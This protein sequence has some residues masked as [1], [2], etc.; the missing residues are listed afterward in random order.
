MKPT[1]VDAYR[2]MHDGALALARVE[3][4]GICVDVARL[5]ETIRDVGE[6]I[7]GLESEQK[8]DEVWSAWRRRFGA[9]ANM[10]SRDQLTKVVYDELGHKPEGTTR[11]GKRAKADVESLSKID[12]PFVRRFLEVEKLKKL[13]STYLM[14]VLREVVNGLLHPSFNLH[15]VRTYR[16]SSDSPNFQNIPI[17][18]EEVGAMIRRCFVPRPGHVLVEIDYKALEFRVCA[19]HWRDEAM[20]RYASDPAL[21]IHRDMAKELYLLDG[22]CS[23]DEMKRARFHAKNSFVFATLY[24]SYWRNTSRSLW[25]N[26]VRLT[27]GGEPMQSW[28][29]EQGI[30][31]LGDQNSR[32]GSRPGTYGYHVE[33]VERRFGERFPAWRDRKERWLELYR[34]RGWFKT[35]TGFVCSGVYSRNDLYNYPIQGPAFHC[36]LWSLIRLVRWLGKSGMRSRIVGQIHDSI[37][38]DVHRDELADYVAEARRTMTEDIRSAWPWIITP[39]EVEVEVAEDNWF[40]KKVYELN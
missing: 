1:I 17:R 23:K 3:E 35:M 27:A 28:L 18:D 5:D 9:K 6:R 39:L 37:L 19:C 25:K 21:D 29:E 22:R 34:K 11:L 36:L 38:A 31:G 26:A 24:G 14:G 16:S 2:L 8:S 15:L 32:K 20:V 4:A 40:G 12:L 10:G 33:S 13:R 7:E 30:E